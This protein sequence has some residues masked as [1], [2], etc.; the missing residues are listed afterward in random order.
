MPN[1]ETQGLIL[2]TGQQ[3]E[4]NR[5]L[6]TEAAGEV[7]VRF[8]PS[9]KDAAELLGAAV[10]VAGTV[11]GE[12]LAAAPG[13]RWV[14]SWAAGANNDLTPEMVASDVVLTSSVGNG[15]IPLAEHSMLLMM[16][17]NRDVPRW[18]A[19]QRAQTWDRFTHGEL[20]GK[21]V[22]IYGVGHSGSDLAL[23][24]RAFHMRVLGCRRNHETSVPGIDQMYSPD[25]LTEFV[26]ECDFVVVTAPYTSGTA[27][28]FSADVF[29]AMKSSAYWICIS[30][31]GIAADDALLQALQEG[32][33]AGAGI[34]AHGVEPLPSDSPFWTAP[35]TI[36]TPHNGAT[37][38]GTARRGV[39]IFVDNLRRFVAG[40]P[41]QNIVDKVHG[42]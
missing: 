27:G 22:G 17:L 3:S 11:S 13:L 10:A 19:S 6:I 5:Q 15:A 40:Q 14:H 38:Q 35:N 20:N 2:V 31:G 37:T 8:V 4:E 21:T 34:D 32:W 30:R 12:H 28:A 25:Q 41:L 7:P 23:K 33:I 29:R 36:I 1:E 24:A 26:A 16:M 39:E 9:M 42:Y 18:M